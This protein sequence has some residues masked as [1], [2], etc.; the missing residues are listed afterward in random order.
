MILEPTHR[1]WQVEQAA[2]DLDTDDLSL[3]FANT[4]EWRL[5][6]SPV[7][8]LGDYQALVEWASSIGLTNASITEQLAAQARA[9]PLATA[10][11]YQRAIR[12]REAIYGALTALA[13]SARPQ[14][15]DLAVINAELGAALTHLH[16]HPSGRSL[17]FAWAGAD[18]PLQS[19]LWPIVQAAM[20]L[21][22]SP[23]I[24]RLGICADDRGCGDLYLDRSKNHT[25]RYCSYGC[26]NRAKAQ[27]HYARSKQK[28]G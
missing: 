14:D 4:M 16:L 27:R 21:M 1:N 17:E 28:A 26:A 24:S 12:L 13:L 20:N 25:R 22:T 8:E 6:D 19:V 7:E 23:E 2:L 15:A 9:D 18:P 5:S 10:E 11:C 3:D